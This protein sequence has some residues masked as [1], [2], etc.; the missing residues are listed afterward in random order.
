MV[1]F[2]LRQR[3]SMP[4]VPEIRARAEAFLAADA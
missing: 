1:Q 3:R 2:D 4:V